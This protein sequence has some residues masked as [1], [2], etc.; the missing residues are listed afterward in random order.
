M[1]NLGN[2]SKERVIEKLFSIGDKKSTEVLGAYA[3][4]SMSKEV[5]ER[6]FSDDNFDNTFNSTIVPYT[7]SSIIR[8]TSALSQEQ[9]I[10]KLC[11]TADIRSIAILDC[12]S[13]SGLPI[14]ESQKLADKMIDLPMIEEHAKITLGYMAELLSKTSPE[15][16]DEV[17]ERL[18]EKG[19]EASITTLKESVFGSY[20]RTRPDVEQ[21]VVDRLL[22]PEMAS[23]TI[24][25]IKDL[26]VIENLM[27]KA[28]PEVMRS[29]T[30]RLAAAQMQRSAV[31]GNACH[32][33]ALLP[34]VAAAAKPG[35]MTK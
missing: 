16:Q 25:A 13:S 30:S 2:A 22:S 6:M 11:E 21:R 35:A 34:R 9:V 24:A 23:K 7:I 32:S 4:V 28:S 19:D 1:S 18:F 29:M 10:N 27:S 31:P 3:I 26:V 17:I 15:K 20:L 14:A 33:S 8:N 5:S 12:Y